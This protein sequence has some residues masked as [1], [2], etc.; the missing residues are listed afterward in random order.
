MKKE[1]G[2]Y[3]ISNTRMESF[4]IATLLVILVHAKSYNWD[5]YPSVL[6]KI[7]E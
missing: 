5:A 6:Y 7:C 3:R 4:G 2:T 1:L